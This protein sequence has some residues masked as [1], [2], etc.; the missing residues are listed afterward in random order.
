MTYGHFTVLLVV[1]TYLPFGNF[2]D[3]GPLRLSSAT[4]SIE[5]EKIDH[6][7]K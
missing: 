1:R 4:L 3:F 6:G 2:R 5:N 7:R